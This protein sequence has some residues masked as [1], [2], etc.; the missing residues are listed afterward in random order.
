MQAC[1]IMLSGAH[2]SL[3]SVKYTCLSAKQF[4]AL[5]YKEVILINDHTLS[6]IK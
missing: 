6:T 4:L 2:E 1:L 5:F 3:F